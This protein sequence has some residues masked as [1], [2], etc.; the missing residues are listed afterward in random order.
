MINFKWT[1]DGTEW[2]NQFGQSWPQWLAAKE[3]FFARLSKGSWK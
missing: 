3:A 1:W 2:V